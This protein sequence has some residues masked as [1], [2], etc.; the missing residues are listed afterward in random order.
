MAHGIF[1]GLSTIDLVYKV[2]G[3][4]APNSKVAAHDQQVFVGG[5]ATNA[6]IAFR[7]LGGSS[8]LVTG[9]GCH[10]LS[11]LIRNELEQY[12]VRW[13]DLAPALN[14]V[15]AISSIAVNPAG[16]RNVI[17]ANASRFGIPAAVVD[18]RAL[19]GASILLVD[20]HFMQAATVWAKAARAR[21]IPV[22]FDG[23]SWK[24]GTEELLAS[25]DFALCSADFLPPG[26]STQEDVVR[27]LSDSG[28]PNIAITN[29]AEPIRFESPNAAGTLLIPPIEV[30]DTMGAGDIFHG[31]FC[32]Y[33]S[34]RHPFQQALAQAAAVATHSCRFRGTREWMN[35][36]ISLV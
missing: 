7:H 23:G 3:F 18:E 24:P 25:V 29:G 6:A 4:P 17:S 21:G 32:H 28:V 5:P 20:G 16:E 27:F 31:A 30:L 22:V 14:E 13:I 15:P 33:L 8:T 10:P 34:A 11:E 9:A 26:C 19:G 12:S 1:V 35:H 2:D 36:A